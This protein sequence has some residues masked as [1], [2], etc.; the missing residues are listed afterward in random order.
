METLIG[1]ERRKKLTNCIVKKIV[2]R[3][4]DYES[5]VQGMFDESKSRKERDNCYKRL[6]L[7]EEAAR[8]KIDMYDQFVD[9]LEGVLEL[10]RTR[11]D[12]L[13]SQKLAG[14]GVEAS[15]N[16]A[17][18]TRGRGGVIKVSMDDISERHLDISP[19]DMDEL[20]KP[21]SN[22]PMFTNNNHPMDVYK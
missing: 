3:Q 20:L 11:S 8:I 2:R 17:R 15:A 21:P 16:P 13:L 9:S 5:A 10:C 19:E 22:S 7:L 14:R 1:I 4:K 6:P 18:A 12:D